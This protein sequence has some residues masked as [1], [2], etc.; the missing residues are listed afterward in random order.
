MN[1]KE[2]LGVSCLCNWWWLGC[3]GRK[4]N[5]QLPPKDALRTTGRQFQGIFMTSSLQNETKKIYQ[6]YPPAK[7]NLRLLKSK[8]TPNNE[9]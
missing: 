8:V 9:A 4:G 6:I 5:K 1:E 2:I 3:R 7:K